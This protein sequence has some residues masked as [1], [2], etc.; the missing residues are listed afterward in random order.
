MKKEI[1]SFILYT[2]IKNWQAFQLYIAF[3]QLVENAFPSSPKNQ[4]LGDLPT[5]ERSYC[6]IFLTLRRLQITVQ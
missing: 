2:F 5:C 4:P 6:T 1:F 3:I